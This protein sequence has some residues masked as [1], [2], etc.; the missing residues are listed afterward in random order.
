MYPPSDEDFFH[1]RDLP[2]ADASAKL[3]NCAIEKMLAHAIR[4]PQ[5]V[6]GGKRFPATGSL[7]QVGAVP[8]NSRHE[9]LRKLVSAPARRC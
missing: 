9:E 7:P 8:A 1:A 3:T 2:S 6:R 4:E 5:L